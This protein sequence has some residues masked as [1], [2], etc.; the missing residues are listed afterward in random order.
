MKIEEAK[1]NLEID[2]VNNFDFDQE[3]LSRLQ[4]L[5]KLI[6][7]KHHKLDNNLISNRNLNEVPLDNSISTQRVTGQEDINANPPRYPY[8]LTMSNLLRN[9]NLRKSENIKK[10]LLDFLSL[11]SKGNGILL[12]QLNSKLNYGGLN[13]MTAMQFHNL[14]NT[15]LV[16]KQAEEFQDEELNTI[17]TILSLYNS[18]IINSISANNDNEQ[19]FNNNQNINFDNNNFNENNNNITSVLQEVQNTQYGNGDVSNILYN[20]DNDINQDQVVKGNCSLN[21]RK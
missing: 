21:F 13:P 18:Y 5:Y 7:E 12:N 11:L 19:D 15:L 2:N 4:Q 6:K 17:K 10:Y 16:N 1:S 14:L 8:N 3:D 9:D 20:E